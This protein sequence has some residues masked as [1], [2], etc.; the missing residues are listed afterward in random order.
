[1][2]VKQCGLRLLLFVLFCTP[3]AQRLCAQTPARS[4]SDCRKLV[5]RDWGS[6]FGEEWHQHEAV[7]WGCRLGAPPEAVK[8]WR[9]TAQ[10]TGM[11]QN[12]VRGAIDKQD[13]IFLEQVEGT[14]RCYSFYALK[15]GS[16]GWEKVWEEASDSYCMMTCPP[17]RMRILS[18]YVL[19]NL[20][21]SSSLECRHRFDRKKY[22][23]NGKTFQNVQPNSLD[24]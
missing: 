9:E 13:F 14:M 19:L 1:M 12:V 10:I 11:I 17:V 7:Y 2:T 18:S 21:N 24:R 5:P 20:P 16:T 3:F 23:W 8:E 15:K 4:D 6:N 22:L